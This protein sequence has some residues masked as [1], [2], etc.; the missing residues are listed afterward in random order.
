LELDDR[1]IHVSFVIKSVAKIEVGRGVVLVQAIVRI[2]RASLFCQYAVCFQVQNI[3]TASVPVIRLP[4]AAR[5]ICH[6][7]ASH[8]SAT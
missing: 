7:A 8:V 1:F 6:S 3:S 2:H 4:M 5:L